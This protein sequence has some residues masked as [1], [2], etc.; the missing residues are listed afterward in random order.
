[1]E[2]LI[3]SIQTPKSKITAVLETETNHV[4]FYDTR[5][6]P[7]SRWGQFIS[8]LSISELMSAPEGSNIIIDSDR[9]ELSF[10][11][12]NQAINEIIQKESF[13]YV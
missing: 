4:E 9:K 1:M 13:N 8:S 11:L 7:H 3:G 10:I 5:F 12:T 2:R 6:N